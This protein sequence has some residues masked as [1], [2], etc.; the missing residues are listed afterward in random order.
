MLTIVYATMKWHHCLFGRRFL[1]ETD[2]KPL[3]DI[4]NKNIGLAPPRIRGMLMQTRQYDFDSRHKPGKEMA[5]PDTLSRLSTADTFEIPGLDIGVHS[6]VDITFTRLKQLVEDTANDQVL[7]RLLSV[8]QKGWPASI[9]SLHQ[10]LR[11]FCS[12]Q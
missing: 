11:P 8:F 2:H 4:K 1:V 3:V 10:D 12:I 9:K 7:Q 6:I 5:L